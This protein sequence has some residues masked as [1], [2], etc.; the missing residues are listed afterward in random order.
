MIHNSTKWVETSAW[1][2][3]C[4]HF[5]REIG[6][7][8]KSGGPGGSRFLFPG[9]KSEKFVLNKSMINNKRLQTIR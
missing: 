3:R 9:M 2:S 1:W 8:M 7:P 6:Y 4:T 5:D